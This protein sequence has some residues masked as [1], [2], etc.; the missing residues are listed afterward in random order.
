MFFCSLFHVISERE[1][2]ESKSK[3]WMNRQSLKLIFNSSLSAI[4]ITGNE[5][6]LKR[7]S[8]G[9]RISPLGWLNYMN[10]DCLTFELHLLPISHKDSPTVIPWNMHV[11][12]IY[13]RWQ[14]KRIEKH[15]ANDTHCTDELTSHICNITNRQNWKNKHHEDKEVKKEKTGFKMPHRERGKKT[16]KHST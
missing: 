4:V 16:W 12:N 5:F 7:V 13:R 6:A 10:T 11:G 3:W 15:S 9:E 14:I 8:A 2:I 1:S